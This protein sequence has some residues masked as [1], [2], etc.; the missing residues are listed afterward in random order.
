MCMEEV[1]SSKNQSY[2]KYKKKR[3]ELKSEVKR[4]KRKLWINF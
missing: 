1:P 4:A 3:D 2:N